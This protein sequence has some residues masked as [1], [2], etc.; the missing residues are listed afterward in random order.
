MRES[1]PRGFKALE[2]TL[3]ALGVVGVD[4]GRLRVAGGLATAEALAALLHGH[5]GLG[6]LG[7]L[8]DRGHEGRGEG[9]QHS[10]E[11]GTEHDPDLPRYMTEK[12]MVMKEDEASATAVGVA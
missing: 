5:L 6:Q 12:K 1:K 9:N 3:L 10:D 8:G 2:H 11:E 7:A 4:D